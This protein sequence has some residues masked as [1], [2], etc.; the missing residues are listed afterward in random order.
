VKRHFASSASLATI[1]P[2]SAKK[3]AHGFEQG[4]SKQSLLM[5]G[6]KEGTDSAAWSKKRGPDERK[7]VEGS[8]DKRH[9]KEQDVALARLRLR[10][11]ILQVPRSPA[12]PRT[13][14]STSDVGTGVR[15]VEAAAS[16]N[17]SECGA[18]T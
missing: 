9:D 18:T 11:C 2:L 13:C 17:T 4:C 1:K 14:V 3:T 5:L 8:G 6:H 10:S 7:E 16:A 12:R 15:T